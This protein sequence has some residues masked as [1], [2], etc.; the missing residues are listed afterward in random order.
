MKVKTPIG[1]IL[2]KTDVTGILRRQFG[3][4]SRSEVVL[5]L[6]SHQ[7]KLNIVFQYAQFY[8]Q[9]LLIARCYKLKLFHRLK[10]PI[11][12]VRPVASKLPLL[13]FFVWKFRFKSRVAQNILE[14]F[15]KFLDFFSF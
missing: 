4:I 10:S 5:Y 8:Q 11:T 7:V 1:I 13:L 15:L 12:L 14:F 2:A 6:L 3:I 9:M